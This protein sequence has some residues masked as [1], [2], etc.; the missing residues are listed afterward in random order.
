MCH[1]FLYKGLWLQIVRNYWLDRYFYTY[2][3]RNSLSTDIARVVDG[4]TV[5]IVLRIYP[6]LW[7]RD[8]SRSS[9]RRQSSSSVDRIRV[10]S[11]KK[12]KTIMAPPPRPPHHRWTF[13]R[14]YLTRPYRRS[15]SKSSRVRRPIAAAAPL[16]RKHLHNVCRAT[17]KNF[18]EIAFCR[19][20]SA[21]T[22]I[23][24]A[25]TDKFTGK[26]DG[27]RNA[28]RL[29][30]VW[31]RHGTVLCWPKRVSCWKTGRTADTDRPAV[32]V[33]RGVRWTTE[34]RS[35]RPDGEKQW[36][37]DGKSSVNEF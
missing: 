9:F 29:I 20:T 14:K 25:N 5:F 13:R 26:R 33:N 37:R 32:R 23:R 1:D 24:S 36:K 15:G 35:R 21:W 16:V 19:R 3:I 12:K 27:R 2:T 30:F 17:G 18:F 6:Y 28:V 8:I 31:N 11:E 34:I 10:A 7:C 4:E 22:A